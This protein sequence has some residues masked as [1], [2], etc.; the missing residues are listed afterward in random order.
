MLL[1]NLERHIEAIF[2]R[3][4]ENQNLFTYRSFI[5]LIGFKQRNDIGFKICSAL[6][7]FTITT[8]PFVL[9]FCIADF[10]RKI[11]PYFQIF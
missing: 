8:V 1:K 4:E 11:C 9:Q 2:M 3:F 7:E 6:S 5:R 10:A